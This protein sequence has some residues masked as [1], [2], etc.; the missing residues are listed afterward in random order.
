MFQEHI[1][2]QVA[3]AVVQFL[4]M[5]QSLLQQVEMVAVAQAVMVAAM[6]QFQLAALQIQAAAAVLVVVVLKVVLLEQAVQAVQELLLFVTPV[7]R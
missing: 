5:E 4:I 6:Q 1:F 7:H 2:M 3:V